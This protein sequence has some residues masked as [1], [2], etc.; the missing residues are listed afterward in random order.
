MM[1]ENTIVTSSIPPTHPL[2]LRLQQRTGWKII[3]NNSKK[4]SKN[5]ITINS[6]PTNINS[7]SALR[8][9]HRILR[10]SHKKGTIQW[11]KALVKRNLLQPVKPRWSIRGNQISVAHYNNFFRTREEL[12]TFVTDL[13]IFGNNFIETAHINDTTK[14]LIH[15]PIINISTLLYNLNTSCSFWWSN[16]LMDHH[17]D[18]LPLLFS[19]APRIDSIFFPGGDGGKL[20]WST[21]ATTAKALRLNHSNAGIWVSAQEVNSTTLKSFV[22]EITTNQTIQNILGTNGGVVYGPHN[23][24]PFTQ[25]LE[26]FQSINQSINV[27]QYPDLAHSVDSQFALLHWDGPYAESYQRQVVNPLPILHASIVKAR[28]DGSSNNIGVG[29]YSEGL[30]DDLNKFI[31]SAMGADSSI[32][33]VQSVVDEYC[34]YFFGDDAAFMMSKGLMG[35]EQNWLNKIKDNG[36]VIKQTLHF[37]Q[38]GYRSMSIKEQNNNWRATMYL[39]RGFMDQYIYNLHLQDQNMLV[40]ATFILKKYVQQQRQQH[41]GSD[42]AGGAD[43]SCIMAVDNALQM[44]APA[45]YSNASSDPFVSSLRKKIVSLAL[46]LDQQVGANVLQTQDAQL[47][48]KSIDSQMY[49]SSK[50]LNSYLTNIT[51]NATICQEKIEEYL[52]WKNP[53]PGGYYDNFGSIY[54]NDHSH[55][56]TNNRSIVDPSCFNQHCVMQGGSN[57]LIN[58]KP[59][60]LRYGM[61]MYDN[62]MTIRYTNIDTSSHYN[63]E[64]VMW[65]CWFDC[66]NDF[67]KFKVN[68]IEL[69]KNYISAP[70]PMKKLIFSIPI[71]AYNDGIIEITCERMNGLGGNG[72]TC[73]LTEAWLKKVSVEEKKDNTSKNE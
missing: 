27:R 1:G 28:S 40:N 70:N 51:K 20:E 24:I 41:R 23:R 5:L 62:K 72:K 25:F 56:I 49:K 54:Q 35:L 42:G 38:L 32:M 58:V 66:T 63:W 15:S 31:W 57:V 11:D 53:G 6:I 37:L 18:E 39:R 71:E 19:L 73:Q 50:F 46:D 30:N 60:W 13:S 47:N 36:D 65:Y 34:Q 7:V 52:H 21:I 9:F 2:L 67:V 45:T 8:H 14:S 43:N 68:G 44:L 4:D 16:T 17:L 59:D 3:R 55:L 10:I 12:S 26:Q 33:N 64:V 22:H 69:T 61:V 48:M 29:A